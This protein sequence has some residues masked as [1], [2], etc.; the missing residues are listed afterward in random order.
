MPTIFTS[1]PVGTSARL[2]PN[3]NASSNLRFTPDTFLISPAKPTSPIATKSA[4]KAKPFAAEAIA[5]AA[6][7]SAAGSLIFIPPTVAT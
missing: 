5:S 7:K 3:R 6:A 1:D 2:K 4:G